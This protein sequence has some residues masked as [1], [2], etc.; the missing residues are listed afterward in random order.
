VFYESLPTGSAGRAELPQGVA[1]AIH[2][3]ADRQ[4]GPFLVGGHSRALG[5]LKRP[6][7]V[8]NI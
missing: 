7:E 1:G 4:K 3:L 5:P 8:S 6:S 2:D